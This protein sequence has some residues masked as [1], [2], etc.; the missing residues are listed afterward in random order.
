MV[1]V[2][3]FGACLLVAVLVSGIAARTVL[4]TSLIFLL[5]GAL[6]G[7]GGLGLVSLDADSPLVGDLADLALFTVLFVDGTA[8]RNLRGEG[9]WRQPARALGI[10]MPLAFAGVA[11][12][13]HYVADFDWITAMLVGAVL[14]PTDPVFA[15][16]I[17]GRRDVPARLRRLLSVESGL[18]DGLALPAVV[19]LISAAGATTG[20][21]PSIGTVV[22]ELLGGLVLGVT[23]PFLIHQ[24]LRLPGLGAEPKIQPLG[25]LAVGILLY[26]VAHAT[27]LNPYL[28]AFAG[29]IVV[30]RLNPSAQQ[31]F[32]PL[33]E[34][35]AELAKFAA[36]LVFGALLT[37]ALLSSIGI[38]GWVVAV[39]ALILV[40]PASLY[41]S[42]LGS[43]LT[44]KELFAAAW[45]GPKGF[46]SV[47]YGLLVLH[48][49]IPQA[50][51]AYELVAVCIGLSIIA[52][53]STDVPVAKMFSLEAMAD[54]PEDQRRQTTTTGG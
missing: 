35:L 9:S 42:L 3:L 17:V 25:A 10:G 15:S 43:D 49:G 46:A 14:A 33:G 12:L 6:A 40:R 38:G 53:S 8:L 23:L 5:A 27:G 47:V 31:A 16:A 19:I 34:Q 18:N 7:E 32:E 29:G 24:L 22:L 20:E 48:S 4:S 51:D 45:F 21:H 54:L 11:V 26:G 50:T 52:H 1:L 30:A 2:I 36:L 13:A 41:L 39:L 44:R 37:P 28:A